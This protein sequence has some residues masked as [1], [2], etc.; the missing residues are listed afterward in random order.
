[1]AVG[2]V[3]LP[4]LFGSQYEESVSAFLLLAPGAIGYTAMTVFSSAAPGIR[5][6]S[7]VG[8]RSGGLRVR[9]RLPLASL[10]RGTR[11][12]APRWRPRSG[13]RPEASSRWFAYWLYAS[14]PRSA[15]SSLAHRTSAAWDTSSRPPLARSYVGRA[16]RRQPARRPLSLS[17]QAPSMCA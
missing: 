7:V 5:C 13:L 8:R 9:P 2:P 4:L 3:A 1:M 12:T 15:S 10:V 16:A 17:N 11:P 6:R 14:R